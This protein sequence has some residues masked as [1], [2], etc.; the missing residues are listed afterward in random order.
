M[1][2]FRPP[3]VTVQR[4]DVG[5]AADRADLSGGVEGRG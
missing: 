1:R 2:R 4:I 3:S 5:E